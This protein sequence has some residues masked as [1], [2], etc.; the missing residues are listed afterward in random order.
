MAAY[1]KP[2][3]VDP[4][5]YTYDESGE[6]NWRALFRGTSYHNTVLVDDKNQARYEWKKTRFKITGP[7]P[8]REIKSFVTR[9][10]LDYL[11]G[12]A[13]SHE[14]P[15]VH[16]RKVLFINGEYW[17]IVDL[18]RATEP[19]KYDLLFHLSPPAQG[20]VSVMVSDDALS[21]QSPQLI[22]AQP[23]SPNVR[24][25]IQEGFVSTSYGE[26]QPAPIVRLTQRD[27]SA[28]FLTVLYPHMDNE[29][30]ISVETPERDRGLHALLLGE[31]TPVRITI[32]RNGERYRDD[33][34]FTSQTASPIGTPDAP[35]S[36]HVRVSRTDHRERLLFRYQA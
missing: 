34:L 11:H 8:E 29:T 7:E 32:A 18:L 6:T 1:G 24:P 13:R 22:L 23:F 15:V 5:R 10:G 26:K 3:I 16:E 9:P 2:L 28:C 4:G 31:Q 27:S 20:R 35:S 14:Y 21:I 25:S 19:H 33:L 12:I 30:N 36:T 17:V